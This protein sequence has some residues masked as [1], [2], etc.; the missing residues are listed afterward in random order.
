MKKIIA[1]AA[2]LALPVW[3]EPTIHTIDEYVSIQEPG[4]AA[5]Y[6]YFELIEPDKK[7]MPVKCVDDQIRINA[8]L[9]TAGIAFT[10]L[11][12]MVEDNIPAQNIVF[13]QRD[14]GTCYLRNIQRRDASSYPWDISNVKLSEILFNGQF[15]AEGCPDPYEP[16]A[17]MGFEYQVQSP[18]DTSW[19]AKYGGHMEQYSGDVCISNALIGIVFP[20]DHRIRWRVTTS[21]PNGFQEFS[22][23]VEI[24]A[25]DTP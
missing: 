18:Y 4:V 16:V 8:K 10:M 1:L 11:L 25:R 14:N 20:K 22:E 17:V 9:P 3:A 15:R 19:S 24:L 5:R 6:Y 13:A 2:V 12:T 7:F 23:W 21:V